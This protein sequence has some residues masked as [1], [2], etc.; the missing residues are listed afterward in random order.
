[1]F[2]HPS[3]MSDQSQISRFQYQE[4]H[5]TCINHEIRCYVKSP[6]ANYCKSKMSKIFLYSANFRLLH[7][8][9]STEKAITHQIRAQDKRIHKDVKSR[10]RCRPAEAPIPV[11]LETTEEN[12][13]DP[14]AG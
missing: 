4:E 2:S 12:D 5:V 6:F 13:D 8:G 11:F 7:D 10:D 3:Y 14:E 9:P 1:M